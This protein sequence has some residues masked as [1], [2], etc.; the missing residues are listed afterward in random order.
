MDMFRDGV[1]Y[2]SLFLALYVQIFLL[3]SY[4][5]W[6][7]KK[8]VKVIDLHDHSLPR[9]SVL[10]PCYN[11]EKTVEKT[12]DSL[13]ELDYPHD[14]LQIIVIDD[15]SSD[16]TWEIV[17]VYAENPRVLLLTKKN[18][19]SKYAALN[20]G[21][22]FATGDIIGCLD[23][24][25]RVTPNALR[26]SMKRLLEAD[27]MAVVPA[28]Y[29][30]KPN[31]LLLYIQKVEF[32]FATFLRAAL[33]ELD[34]IYIAPG[35]F[36]LFRKEVF[37][38]LG[39]YKEAHHTED[40]EMALRMQKNN[41][42]IVFAPDSI[43]Y[44]MG[45]R[46]LWPL[47]R[48]RVRWIYGFIMNAVDYRFMM[49]RSQFGHLGFIVLPFSL[50]SLLIIIVSV[51]ILVYSL[52]APL[53]RAITHISAVGITWPS[54]TFD[55]FYFNTK[56]PIILGYVAILIMFATIIIARRIMKAKRLVT[57]DILAFALYPYVGTL[58]TVK[59]VWNAIRSKKSEWRQED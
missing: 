24:D 38:T 3:L 50:A 41:M 46:R 26:A 47:V 39:V 13:L 59:A 27:A 48:Q 58:W 17:Q 11:E 56:S 30:D 16:R 53:I 9:V 8:Q 40:L 1:L 51:P 28:M 44:T 4:L 20:Y 5:G 19:G 14:R 37:E 21:I 57:P 52:S 10:V 33:Q 45:M 54:F 35:P 36:S 7:K 31:N 23:A 29:I 55:S 42:K 6:K 12:V 49:F 2:V 43:V 18:E 22:T 34:A 25:S 15:G 32:E